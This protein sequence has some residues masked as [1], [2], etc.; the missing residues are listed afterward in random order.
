MIKVTLRKSYNRFIMEKKQF[1]K[2]TL[3]FMLAFLYVGINSCTSDAEVDFENYDIDTD[4]DG[5]FDSQE[6]LDGTDRNN[7]CDPV[8]GLDYTGFNSSNLLW[9]AGDCDSDGVINEVELSLNSNPYGNP[10]ERILAVAEFLPNLSEL[11]LFK[12]DITNFQY[13]DNV[14]EYGLNTPLYSDYSQKL[15]VLSIPDGK[16]LTYAGDGLL[17]FPD[18]SIMAKTF[19]YYFDERN[20]SLGKKI[21][22]TR[23]LIKKDGV[24]LIRDYLWNEEQ[25]D[26]VLDDDSHT[27]A[28]NWIDEAGT[29]RSVDY[30]VPSNT[31]CVQ[32][33]ENTNDIFPIGPKSRAMNFEHNGQNVLQFFKDNN[34]I[35]NAPEVSEISVLPDWT[36][37][38]LALE[39]RARAYLDVNCAHCHQPGGTYN[40]SFGDGFQFTYETSFE[41]SNIDEVSVQIKDRMNTQI[42]GYFM[43]LIGVS[44]K[45]DEGIALINAYVDSL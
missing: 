16:Q 3:I 7:P 25:T 37:E 28:V 35:A 38:S 24:W 13:S 1:A 2:A 23:V 32:C 40:I 42:S 6:V 19:F 9:L 45:H 22:E 17:D 15:R 8:H 30:E 14:Y 5:I 29:T 27:I 41:D 10:I 34:L 21:I 26:A 4:G 20:P 31:M 33:H 11:N 44:L 18:N 36:D 43:P 12:G 39:D